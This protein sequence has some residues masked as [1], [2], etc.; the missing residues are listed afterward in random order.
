M[1]KTTFLAVVL[2][3]CL[4]LALL[5]A[6][7][8]S[9]D[10]DR[11]TK[12]DQ[13]QNENVQ[14]EHNKNDEK[15]TDF[16][17]T[18]TDDEETSVGGNSAEELEYEISSIG[19]FNDGLAVITT[20]IGYGYINP[21][22]EVVIQPIFD[23]ACDFQNG[24]ACVEKSSLYGYINTRGE[25]IFEPQFT[26]ASIYFNKIAKVEKNGSTQ[27][28]NTQG[29]VLYSINGKE[30]EIGEI[31]NGSF[32]VE[33]VEELISGNVHTITYYKHDGTKVSI[34]NAEHVHYRYNYGS[35]TREGHE[36]TSLN[37][38]GYALVKRGNVQSLIKVGDNV[39]IVIDRLPTNNVNGNRDNYYYDLDAK[40]S[41]YIDYST[42][43]KAEGQE[44]FHDT[45]WR[46]LGNNYYFVDTKRSEY[47]Y[48][49]VLLHK[50]KVVLT[51]GEIEEFANATPLGV[52][53][54]EFN[55]KN[56]FAVVLESQSYVKFTALMDENGNILISPTK[57]YIFVSEKEEYEHGYNI[58]YTM[59]PIVDGIFRVK[60][61]ETCLYGYVDLS[62]NW[63]IE[64]K[65]TSACDFYGEGNDAVAVVNENTI[66]NR[67]GE[68]VFSAE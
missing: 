58:I 32:W 53:R 35:T 56:Y 59:T 11:P 61:V 42:G 4:M 37:E 63:I 49:Y 67:K 62:G 15:Q 54:C 43:E 46:N 14:E 18:Q 48:E 57:E 68:T 36:I 1:K 64:P 52:S 30:V 50:D 41:Y 12:R 21:K 55:G 3:L 8:S 16:N 7:T 10:S 34:S 5:A 60:S 26:S 23:S 19:K 40:E 6:C 65:Y 9:D 17:S 25:Y 39:E 24:I 38:F 31:K 51:F 44:D 20:N 27:Y 13:E 28:I 22:G 29:T 33:T 47:N 2:A 45:I 66:I